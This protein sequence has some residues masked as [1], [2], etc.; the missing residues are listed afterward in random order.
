MYIVV[1]LCVL[2]L[3]FESG[4]KCSSISCTLLEP[5]MGALFPGAV[6][7]IDFQGKFLSH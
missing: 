5:C 2:C 4:F 7:C 1:I 3:C 6:N